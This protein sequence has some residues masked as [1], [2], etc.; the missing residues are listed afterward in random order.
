MSHPLTSSTPSSLHRLQ[1][2][3][4][5]V[6]RLQPPPRDLLRRRHL[7]LLRMHRLDFAFYKTAP[8]SRS[9]DQN[10]QLQSASAWHIFVILYA[11]NSLD[12]L[13]LCGPQT[14]EPRE[15]PCRIF[16][17]RLPK[18]RANFATVFPSPQWLC[19]PASNLE[20]SV[21]LTMISAIIAPKS[22]TS[23]LALLL[24]NPPK[25]TSNIPLSTAATELSSA[26]FSR[27]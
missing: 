18:R 27:T 11:L 22:F 25:R 7:L 5:S 6:L 20:G 8:G 16:S 2:P 12:S 26:I 15:P 21:T 4:R 19:L 17:L 13:N 23:C 24:R 14:T 3:V 1:R 9:L 10:P